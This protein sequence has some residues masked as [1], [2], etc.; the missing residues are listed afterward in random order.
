VIVDITDEEIKELHEIDKTH[1]FR[2]CHPS[3]TGWGG[4][5]FPDCK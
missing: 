4:L 1:H 2:A 5:G 3:W